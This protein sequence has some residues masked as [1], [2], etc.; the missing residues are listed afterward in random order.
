MIAMIVDVWYIAYD[1]YSNDIIYHLIWYDIE[2]Y[3][4]SFVS[5]DMIK[6]MYRTIQ[7]YDM[8]QYLWYDTI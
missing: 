5:Y 2:Y 6:I 4:V 1:S 3:T 7:K 8:I